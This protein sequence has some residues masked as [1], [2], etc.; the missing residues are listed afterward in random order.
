M[1][2]GPSRDCVSAGRNGRGKTLCTRWASA[3]REARECRQSSA[4]KKTRRSGP[5]ATCL[6]IG[7]SVHLHRHPRDGRATQ[8][9][10]G[11]DT[12]YATHQG[13]NQR[14]RSRLGRYSK[15]KQKPVGNTH[16]SE[17]WPRALCIRCRIPGNSILFPDT[18]SKDRFSEVGRGFR[19]QTCAR[20]LHRS[21]QFSRRVCIWGELGSTR[22]DSEPQ[23]WV[24]PG[25]EGLARRGRVGPRVALAF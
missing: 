14:T 12:Q 2:F 7:R 20:R 5:E 16:A 24:R 13:K 19:L 8:E 25:G 21:T 22:T 18:P 15:A 11:G 9:G 4:R 10:P 3:S 17:G 1:A 23:P 6:S